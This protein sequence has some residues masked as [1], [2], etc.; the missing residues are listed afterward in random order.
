M[1]YSF[2]ERVR[3]SLRGC[4]PRLSFGLNLFEE[5]FCLDFFGFLIALPILDRWHRTPHEIMEKW[6]FYFMHDTFVIAKGTKTKHIYLPW[7]WNHCK[8]EVRKSDG[9]WVPFVGSW[10]NKEPDGREIHGFFY[11]YT[12]KS[13]EVQE[14]TAE[15]YVERRTWKWHWFPMLPFPKKVVTSLSI[16][17]DGEVGEQTGSWKGGVTGCGWDVLPGEDV[18]TAFRRMERDRKFK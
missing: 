4:S 5:E 16:N 17:F 15:V 8:T 13:G 10:E 14:R 3:R 1:H 7:M 18:E 9:S 12:L 6:G 11:R 2:K